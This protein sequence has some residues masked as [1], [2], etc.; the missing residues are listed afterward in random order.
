[1]CLLSCRQAAALTWLLPAGQVRQLSSCCERILLENQ[2]LRQQLQMQQGQMGLQV[3]GGHQM[4]VDAPTHLLQVRVY[5]VLVQP[6]KGCIRLLCSGLQV[7]AAPL[8]CTAACW[9]PRCA[10]ACS[11]L[12][13]SLPA[14]SHQATTSNLRTAPAWCRVLH[15]Q[16]HRCS[17]MCRPSQ[18]CPR[19]ST[20]EA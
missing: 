20:P 18:A 6:V 12:G 3:M 15:T 9:V 11:H 13:D 16:A 10:G 19:T 14:I 17:C 2:L 4:R 5:A 8:C 1:M 7:S